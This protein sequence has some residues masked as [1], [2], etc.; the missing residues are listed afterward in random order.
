MSDRP[1]TKVRFAMFLTPEHIWVEVESGDVFNGIGETRNQ[2][3]NDPVA[4][5]WGT[6]V[7]FECKDGDRLRPQCVAIMTG[8][9]AGA[10]NLDFSKPEGEEWKQ[11]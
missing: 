8:P 1:F 5:P 2:S 10:T 3:L 7:R 11:A 9:A 4:L 6:R